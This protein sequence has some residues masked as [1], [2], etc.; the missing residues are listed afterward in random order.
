M[1]KSVSKAAKKKLNPGIQGD[2]IEK[3]SWTRV[4]L[5]MHI[6]TVLS[7][8]VL[9]QITKW[10][11]LFEIDHGR[12]RISIWEPWMAIIHVKNPGAAFGLFAESS[13]I[14]RL[15]VFGLVTLA[16]VGLL[17]YW[18]GTTPQAYRWQRFAFALVLG[19]AFG[20]LKDRILFQQVTDFIAVR[21]PL[22][23]LQSIN[24]NWISYYD[25]PTFNVADMAISTGVT[26]IFIL[27]TFE[28]PIQRM[29]RKA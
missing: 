28:K 5:P 10:W 29:R 4:L 18:L 7:V 23:F 21:I 3:F 11:V 26:L 9:D 16:C 27:L 22:G 2:S 19:G 17:L 25:W 1:R 6:W 20:N 15:V 12:E 13:L 14:F 8:F 24:E